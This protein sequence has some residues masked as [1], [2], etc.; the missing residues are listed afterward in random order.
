MDERRQC[1]NN[2]QMLANVA[3]RLCRDV[4]CSYDMPVF[5]NERL[6][7]IHFIADVLLRNQT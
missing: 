5:T 4:C 7:M 6:K 1:W 3:A 2:V